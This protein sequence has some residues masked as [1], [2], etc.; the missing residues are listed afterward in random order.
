MSIFATMLGLSAE[1]YFKQGDIY[2]NEGRF[3]EAKI[4]FEKADELTPESEKEKKEAI[5]GKIIECKKKL[6]LIHLEMSK[7][8][9]QADNYEKAVESLEVA[10]ELS[11]KSYDT[12]KEIQRELDHSRIKM[13]QKHSDTEAEPLVK[14]A[15]EFFKEESYSEAM[16][17]YREALKLLKYYQE[18]EDELKKHA[19]L[20]LGECETKLAEP[21]VDRAKNFIETEMYEEALTE[22]NQA[23]EILDDDNKL[24]QQIDKLIY[25]AHKKKGAGEAATEEDFIS[26]QEWDEAMEDYKELLNLYFS[27]SYTDSDPFYPVHQN[28]YEEGFKEA[29]KR[30]GNL[31]V[32]RAEGHFNKNKFAVALKYFVEAEKF[33]DEETPEAVYVGEKIEQCKNNIK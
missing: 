15:D 28:K 25:E 29:K 21:Y 8:Y 18:S 23:R 17:E 32:K 31:Y 1:E 22:L 3:G 24:R 2:F 26:K 12:Y 33:F 9:K 4:E 20:K 16:V 14:R 10:L 5:E 13:F 19:H 6:S 30:L 11:D 7:N 27:Y